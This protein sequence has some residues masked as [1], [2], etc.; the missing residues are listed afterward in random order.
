MAPAVVGGHGHRRSTAHQ[1]ARPHTTGG[2][3]CLAR[4]RVE[5]MDGRGRTSAT[6]PRRE[7]RGERFGWRRE[8]RGALRLAT[9]APVLLRPI[10]PSLVGAACIARHERRCGRRAGA[11]EEPARR[12]SGFCTR[13]RARSKQSLPRVDARARHSMRGATPTHR[14][15]RV[16]SSTKAFTCLL[17][18]CLT[19]AVIG[20]VC[21]ETKTRSVYGSQEAR[22]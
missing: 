7:A 2:R 9:C 15:S 22:G 8:A 18:F 12:R 20:F 6:R 10:E 13:M 5:A 17:K 3:S 11:G 1:R 14:A 21:E 4:P 19:C 16:D